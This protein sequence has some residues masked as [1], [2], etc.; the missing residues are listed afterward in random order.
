M[1]EA[2]QRIVQRRST[3][4]FALAQETSQHGVDERGAARHPLMR[5]GDRLIDQGVR[6]VGWR[7]H[8]PQLRKCAEQQSVDRRCGRAWR[9]QCS[10]CLRRAQ[11]AKRVETQ[12]LR[13]SASLAGAALER[14]VERH[15][16]THRL[17][18][19]GAMRQQGGQRQ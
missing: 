11:P 16:G 13:A 7:F 15:P 19:R 9:E 17:H 2:R 10:N 18:R 3:Q 4:R 14:L 12:R 5:R 6:G 8:R 1:I